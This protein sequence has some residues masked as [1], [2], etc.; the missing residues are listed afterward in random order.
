MPETTIL[1]TPTLKPIGYAPSFFDIIKA[2]VLMSLGFLCVSLGILAYRLDQSLVRFNL[3]IDQTT[4]T[5]KA[6]GKLAVDSKDIIVMEQKYLQKDLPR[7]MGKIDISLDTLNGTLVSTKDTVENLDAAVIQTRMDEA[8]LTNQ[9]SGDSHAITVAT[10]QAVNSTNESVKRIGPMVDAAGQSVI[11]IHKAATDLD[12]IILDP[13]IKAALA[14]VKET[15]GSV[16]G[17]ADDTAHYWH[18]LLHPSWPKRI[19]NA[20]TGFGIDA[21]KVLVP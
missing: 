15:T 3:L 11:S 17:M 19:W 8:K 9:L 20:V 13:D 2:T 18:G 5:S 6:V 7:T 10:T 14:N 12:D 4:M 1:P 16:S 21:A